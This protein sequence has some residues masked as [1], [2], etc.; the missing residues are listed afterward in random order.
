VTNIV[1]TGFMGCGK[2]T[3]GKII[4]E[5]LGFRFVDTDL[6]IEERC[7]MTVREI[8]AVR[9]EAAFRSLEEEV[10]RELGKLSALVIAT[11][12]KLMLNP[13]NVRALG[14][15]GRI[16]CLTASP[17]EIL[18]RLGGDEG[19]KRPLLQTEHPRQRITS[20]LEERRE[21][22]RCFMQI[23]TDG[24]SPQTVAEEVLLLL[25]PLNSKA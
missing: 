21:G 19:I 11:G 3:V 15:G 2:S 23:Y 9:G 14:A 12:G 7:T 25:A 1:L 17:E 4:A 8:F 22:Y 5:R 24:K 10:A 18:R 16:F 20:L 6:L 13:A